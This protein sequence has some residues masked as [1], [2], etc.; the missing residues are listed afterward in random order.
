V[1][2]KR[3]FAGGL[4]ALTA[5]GTVA[6]LVVGSGA[7]APERK[8]Q[9]S[10]LAALISDVG[11]FND[12]S[13]NQS[14]LDGLNRARRQFNITTLP[15]ESRTTSDYTPNF[16][17]AV[18]RGANIIIAAGFLLSDT[19]K[20]LAD[21]FPNSRFAITD[22]SARAAPFNG[23][24]RNVTGLTYA[25]EENSYLIGCFAALVTRM[26]GRPRVL[27]VVGGVKIPPVDTFLAGYRAGAR[28]CVPGTRVLIGY[29]QDFVAQDKCRT[30]ALDQLRER[31]QVI[32]AVAGQCGL[33]ALT[34]ARQAGRWGIGVDKDQSTL[35][36][37][38]LTSAV[39]RVDIGVFEAIRR[40]RAGAQFPGGR[41]I[42][43]NLANNGVALGKISPRLPR[44][45][46]TRAMARVNVL[47]TQIV[48]NRIN[49]PKTL[50]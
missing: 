46:R 32:F 14:Q 34:A 24:T 6:A 44:S 40:A 19:T 20:Q 13:F 9:R 33:G 43:F 31:A 23:T 28:R 15:L 50:G 10:F 27:G 42:T 3:F 49:P 2:S 17:R 8:Q 30:V 29:S 41:D 21:Q 22:Y 38:I 5:A 47:R 11:R 25:T 1:R 37:H 4:A 36:R 12:K 48:R 39:K 26:Q 45:I 16:I 18:Q 7:A 35:G